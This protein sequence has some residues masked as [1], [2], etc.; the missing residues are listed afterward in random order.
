MKKPLVAVLCFGASLIC[1]SAQGFI[2]FFNTA[3]TLVTTDT[4]SGGG[5]VGPPLDAGAYFFGLLTSPVGANHFTFA[6]VY[7][8]NQAFAGRF[9]GGGGVAVKGW[10]AGTARDFA[11][12]GWSASEGTTFN[13]A[14]LTGDFAAVGRFGVSSLGT[15][16]A[17]GL[18]TLGF[19]PNLNIFGGTTGI[20][21]GFA[22]Q[23]VT[24][25]PE[26]S[27][28]AL[29]GLGFAVTLIFRCRLL[30][31]RPTAA[32]RAKAC[33]TERPCRGAAGRRR[34]PT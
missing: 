18:T 17:G 32:N 28:S 30:S 15:G 8:T 25:I 33:Q 6:G 20:Q 4:S 23:A 24:P 7:G 1:G 27:G 26:P 19:L 10:A 34:G 14:W 21:T 13:P 16:V 12:V 5:P 31:H 22:L 9:T 3:S 11:V 2:N 29:S